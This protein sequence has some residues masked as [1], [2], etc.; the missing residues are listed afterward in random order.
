MNNP[1]NLKCGSKSERPYLF[2]VLPG[3]LFFQACASASPGQPLLP[4]ESAAETKP[5]VINDKALAV[6][7]LYQVPAPMLSREQTQQ[8]LGAIDTL[9]QSGDYAKA[10]QE[11]DKINPSTLSGQEIAQLNLL[12]AQISL[13]IGEAETA[14]EEL[15]QIQPHFFSLEQKINYLQAQAFAFSLTG[16]PLDSAKARI[17]LNHLLTSPEAL[18]QNQSAIIET[19]GLVSDEDLKN[20]EQPAIG[21]LAGW[22]ALARLYK[23]SAQP[24][25]NVQLRQWRT[26]FPDHPADLS[27]IFKNTQS[28][29][30][31][32]SIHY[33]GSI[34]VILPGSGPFATAGKA[35]K[36]GIMATFDNVDSTVF[37]PNLH[38]YDSEQDT[39]AEL[40]HQA[41][42][43]G[44][45]LIIGPLD[46]K[47]IQRLADSVKLDVPVL[48]LNHI[49]NLE[50][51]NLYQFALSPMD[52]VA[53]LTGKARQ[54]GHKKALLIIPENPQTL[55]IA[56]YFEEYWQGA[57]NT[58][59][60]TQ[61]Y[62]P[63]ETDF[64]E[65]IE[66]LLNGNEN[67][68]NDPEGV[69][70]VNPSS[71][72][73]LDADAVF[74]SAYNPEARAIKQQ[75]NAHGAEGLAVY[76][77]PNIYAGQ[78]NPVQDQVLDTIVF[79]DMPWL[80][81]KAYQGILSMKSLTAI[82]RQ[83]PD[84]YLRLV[85]MGIDAFN[86]SA[87]LNGL[88]S[89]PYQGATGKLFLAEDNRIKRELVCAKFIE[90]KPKISGFIG[91]ADAP[92]EK[93]VSIPADE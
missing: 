5:L 63:K 74:I 13:S 46:K 82:R 34:A 4:E 39:P 42:A 90:G 53:Q 23:L 91:W 69:P 41:V 10:K 79:C 93:A 15:K 22:I 92:D 83:F 62:R 57:E 78:D 7:K 64:T 30:T 35:I 73:K 8:R 37:K 2:I 44:A 19:L 14:I 56:D 89:H 33:P 68:P 16:Q 71:G 1:L 45:E 43:A 25:F 26:T 54:D 50:Q 59:L 75:L 48:A 77:L 60:K 11:A 52:D 72:I 66:K 40:Y 27:L 49:Q 24:G 67:K 3:L 61:T 47:D 88:N 21:G 80:F 38:F 76:A 32:N 31:G 84:S 55:R 20:G 81:D 85:A 17:G 70:S 65:P 51:D 12:T 58:I 86:L 87:R 18:E 6:S 9:I 29:G 36:A 28:P